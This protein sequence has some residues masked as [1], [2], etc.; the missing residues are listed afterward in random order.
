MTSCS[1]QVKDNLQNTDTFSKWMNTV[2]TQIQ[3]LGGLTNP[4][5][6]DVNRLT[7]TIAPDIKAHQDCIAS[8]RVNAASVATNLAAAQKQSATIDKT[9]KQREV[10]VKVTYDRM[11]IA[12][13]PEVTRGYYDGWFPISRPL[14]HYTIPL[15]ISL[16]IFFLF[17]SLFYLLSLFGFNIEFIVA[18]P[19]ILS[20]PVASYGAPSLFKSK[21]FIIMSVIAFILLILTIVGFTHKT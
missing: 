14:K 12:R 20:G 2:N 11:V 1:P 18:L 8:L 16:A 17:L 5:A 15:L 19:V 7:Y 6:D 4:T 10:D 13:N 3:Q 21:P 9:L